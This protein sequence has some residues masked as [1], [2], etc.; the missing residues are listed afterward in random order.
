[1]S[2][3]F[4]AFYRR[5]S[6][7]IR[8]AF[9]PQLLPLL[10]CI[11][12]ANAWADSLP[13][14]AQAGVTLTFDCVTGSDGVLRLDTVPV[15]TPRNAQSANDTFLAE[16]LRQ[17]FASQP[18]NWRTLPSFRVP[19]AFKAWLHDTLKNAGLS[20][21][22]IVTVRTGVNSRWNVAATVTA[23]PYSGMR[24]DVPT[25]ALPAN[26]PAVVVPSSE[27]AVSASPLW[28][29]TSIRLIGT[30]TTA[31]TATGTD[32]VAVIRDIAAQTAAAGCSAY[33]NSQDVLTYTK[34]IEAAVVKTVTTRLG[35][36]YVATVSFAPN[37][38]AT[39]SRVMVVTVQGLDP[40]VSARAAVTQIEMPDNLG[41]RMSLA[42]FTTRFG[43]TRLGRQVLADQ[44][45][46]E[47]DVQ[48]ALATR[49]PLAT[50]PRFIGDDE[51][52]AV[53]RR[54]ATLTGVALVTHRETGGE[55]AFDVLY[56]PPQGAMTASLNADAT[57]EFTGSASFNY[58]WQNGP[59][60]S[61]E[62]TLGLTTTALSASAGTSRHALG[63][64]WNTH[65]DLE[66][67]YQHDRNVRLGTRVGPLVTVRSAD[68]GGRLTLDHDSGVI[69]AGAQHSQ[70]VRA[71]SSLYA[72]ERW[73]EGDGPSAF[74]GQTR[75]LTGPALT[76]RQEFSFEE[77]PAADRTP[78]PVLGKRTLSA[79]VEVTH[80]LPDDH[81]DYAGGRAGISFRQE[82]GGVT[83]S[84]SYLELRG[85]AGL[86][87]QAAPR[88]DFFRLGADNGLCG[89][90]DGE[91]AGRFFAAG[92][93]EAG[94]SLG[95]WVRRASAPAAMAR[96][97]AA[98]PSPLD[99]FYV[100]ALAEYGHVGRQDDAGGSF[101]PDTS[102]SSY[103]LGGR[104]F[105]AVPGVGAAASISFGYAWSPESIRENGRFFTRIVI[106][107]GN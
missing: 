9:L 17:A 69:P 102:A 64:R 32:V 104:F 80:W 105:G 100:F 48:H 35:P 40:V 20:A 75:S 36:P 53:A 46:C 72:R 63:A 68:V 39:G 97:A 23:P 26:T 21:P 78:P 70:R 3:A 43:A 1:M 12:A 25:T 81:P 37:T 62:A 60:L 13:S 49:I 57:R 90:D 22:I 44:R 71:E 50:L 93:I 82:F 106:P 94:H 67:A 65:A 85:S 98:P 10:A 15:L 16:R 30:R 47:T 61:A 92:A 74:L 28:R 11:F 2:S 52:A 8:C 19:D 83:P 91:L 33:A 77:Q 89:L 56:S 29:N 84:D 76:L 88:I 58:H 4:I 86:T 96:T 41:G 34:V 5:A 107:F 31:P 66:G 99:G 79:S 101:N 42:D 27:L 18:E 7:R 54:L 51:R 95:A 6:L 103:A 38:T 14:D 45:R 55:L 73:L 59:R 24:I 87:E